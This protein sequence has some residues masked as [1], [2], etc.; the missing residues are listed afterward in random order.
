MF[1]RPDKNVNKSTRDR[2]DRIYWVTCTID[3]LVVAMTEH[4]EY[5]PYN[6]EDYGKMLR[7]LTDEIKAESLGLIEF[8]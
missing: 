7:M 6:A 8:N 4:S 5:L 3:A 1:N 2:A